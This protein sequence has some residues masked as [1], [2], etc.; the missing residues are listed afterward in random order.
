MRVLLAI[1]L[2]ALSLHAD[3]RSDAKCLVSFARDDGSWSRERRVDVEFYSA[4][5]LYPDDREYPIYAKIWHNEEDPAIVAID[6]TSLVSPE[7]LLFSLRKLFA[8]GAPKYGLD[9]DLGQR[10]RVRALVDG[11]WVDSRYPEAFDPPMPIPPR[12]RFY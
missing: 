4:R 1:F 12:K 6:S 10:W 9:R 8:D 2:A 5:E 3:A 7:F 11:K